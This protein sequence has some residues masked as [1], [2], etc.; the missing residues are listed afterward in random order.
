[1]PGITFTLVLFTSKNVILSSLSHCF[2]KKKKK[3]QGREKNTTNINFLHKFSYY[4]YN[5]QNKSEKKYIKKSVRKIIKKYTC[6]H[7]QALLSQKSSFFLPPFT[8]L[9]QKTH[10]R[11]KTPKKKKLK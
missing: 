3:K 10:A 4:F 6:R 1:M 9:S 11:K 8:F 5:R 2:S 7:T